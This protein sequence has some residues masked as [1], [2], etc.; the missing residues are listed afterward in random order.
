MSGNAWARNG[1]T[2]IVVAVLETAHVGLAGRDALCGPCGLPSMTSEQ[3]PQ[4]PSRQSWSKAMGSSP[5]IRQLFVHHVEHFEERHVGVQVRRFVG[6]ET[7][8]RVRVLLPPDFEFNF[9]AW[10][11]FGLRGSLVAPRAHLHFLVHERLLVEDRGFAA[12]A[13]SQAAT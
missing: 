4:M 7:A 11:M 8:G 2:T 9:H 6:L 12:P 1:S 5:A 10:K 13:Y 3:V